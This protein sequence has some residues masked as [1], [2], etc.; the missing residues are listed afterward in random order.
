MATLPF[1]CSSL[2]ISASGFQSAV[3][4]LGVDTPTLLA[5]L[6]VETPGCGFLSDRRPQILFERHIF[7]RLTG[8]AWDAQYPSISNPVPG[9]YGP[10]GAQQY[11]RL[12]SAVALNQEAA[13]QSASWGLGQ[14]MGENF[15][16]SGFS[17]VDAMVTGMCASEDQQLDAVVGFITSHGLQTALQAQ[18][19]ATYAHGYNGPNYAQNAYDT[20]L[21]HY[22]A[23]FSGSTS[24]PDLTVRAAQV[25]LLFLGFNPQ[26]IDGQLGA[27]TLTALHNF[28]SNNGQPLTAGIDAGVVATL[29]AAMPAAGNLSLV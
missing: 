21:A 3:A 18:D 10:G 22:Y 25:Y 27:N 14:V 9:G 6:T 17:S 26:G 28:Q 8:G 16:E 15:A 12:G 1:P 19:W 24:A 5:L 20:K 2:P 11:A 29:A 4:A 7:S 23:L 13:L